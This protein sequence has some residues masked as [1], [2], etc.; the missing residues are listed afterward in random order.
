MMREK[1]KQFLCLT[2][3]ALLVLTMMPSVL[4]ESFAETTASGSEVEKIEKFQ[5]KLVRGTDSDSSTTW[6]PT[7]NAD[8]HRFVYRI[9]Y[10]FSGVGELP[11]E[12]V[13]IRVPKKLIRDRSGKYNDEFDIGVPE[14][15]D[16]DEND[17]FA[18][19]EGTGDD[20]DCY[21]IYNNREISA[22]QAGSIEVSYS[23]KNKVSQYKD[24]QDSDQF[25]ADIQVDNNGTKVTADA[26]ADPVRINTS[27]SITGTSK[28]VPDG[29]FY[30][31]WQDRW[32]EKPSDA[33]DYYYL[34]WEIKSYIKPH[35]TQPYN[36][37]LDDTFDNGDVVAY[38]FGGGNGFQKSNTLKDITPS[39]GNYNERYDYVLTRHK[40]STYS[41]KN[42]YTVY[43]HITATVN[44]VDQVDNDTKAKANASWYYEKPVY[45]HPTGHFYQMKYGLF[46]GPSR[47]LDNNQEYWYAPHID[48]TDFTNE[49]GRDAVTED[50]EDISDY[51]L[52]EFKAGETN[53]ISKLRYFT[54]VR[55]YPYPWTLPEGKTGDDPSDY[56]KEPVTY[57]LIDN[58][59]SIDGT[60]LTKGDYE[61]S[62]LSFNVEQKTAE[63]EE[64][65][66]DF[67]VNG[68]RNFNDSD[69]LDFYVQTGTND[70]HKACSYNLKSEAFTDVNSLYVASTSARRIF[71]TAGVTGYK[72]ETTNAHWFTQVNL[73]PML[74]L[75]NSKTVMNLV[76]DKTKVKLDNASTGYVYNSKGS[77]IFQKDCTGSVYI[78]GV[79]RESQ[80]LK[81]VVGT[82]NNK[83]KKKFTVL[84][85]VMARESYRD[86]EGRHATGQNGGT[87][88]D[89]APKGSSV[90]PDSIE[91]RDGETIL[92]ESDYTTEIKENYK[93]SGRDLLIIKIKKSGT[94]YNFYVNTVHL[95]ENLKELSYN[96]LNSAVYETGNSKIADGLKDTGGSGADKDLLKDIDPDTDAARFLY[97]E[98]WKTADLVTST[99]TGLQKKVKAKEDADY[100]YATTTYPNDDYTYRIRFANDDETKTRNIVFFDSLENY[101]TPEG[102][103]SDWH[104]TLKGVDT[105][106]LVSD[107]IRPVV[108]YSSLENM[109]IYLHHDLDEVVNGQK[110][111]K[112]AS[113][114][115]DISKAK[116]VAIDCRTASDG[117]AFTLAPGKII[118]A[119]LY[120]HSPISVAGKNAIVYNNI[121]IDKD[122]VA[123]NGAVT[124]DLIHQ[125]YTQLKYRVVAD[126]KLCKVQAEDPGKTISGISFRLYG[127]SD[128]EDDIDMTAA[129]GSDGTLTFKRIPAGTYKLQELGGSDD[130]LVDH[131]QKTVRIDENG[132]VTISDITAKEGVWQ[133]PDKPRI[134]GDLKLYKRST[135]RSKEA[136][137]AIKA[138]KEAGENGNVTIDG[139]KFTVISYRA[140]KSAVEVKPEKSV[141]PGDSTPALNSIFLKTMPSGNLLLSL[142]TSASLPIEGT[143]FHL[144]G[145]SD[146][147]NDVSVDGTTDTTGAVVLKNI[148]K[149]TYTLQE[150]KANEDYILNPSQWTVRIDSSGNASIDNGEQYF[151]GWILRNEPRYHDFSLRKVD[152]ENTSQWLSGAEFRLQGVSELG[153]SVDKAVTTDDTGLAE[154]LDIEKGT[155]ILTETKAPEHHQLDAKSYIVTVTA[156]GDVYVDGLSMDEDGHFTFPDKRTL[157]GKITIT[158]KWVDNKSNDNRP[159]PKVHLTTKKPWYEKQAY[160]VY[161]STDQ[162]M[163]FFRDT[164]EKYTD[165]QVSGT[166]TYYTGFEDITGDT[167]PSWYNSS[168][169][170]QKNTIKTALFKDKI[171]P[172]T[173]CCWFNTAGS[174]TSI[175]GLD[176][177]D[178]SKV[179]DMYCMFNGCNS[180][181]SLDVSSFN[182]ANVTDMGYMFGSGLTSLDLSSFNTAK[183]TNM[184]GMFFSCSLLT[185]A[186]PAWI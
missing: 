6:T 146:Y 127:T 43:N 17:D 92:S 133:F 108:Y 85:H 114:F 157:D 138:L 110:V 68:N 14:E 159:V 63:F 116:A 5:A 147:G 64:D 185:T 134:H 176:K 169:Y 179:T 47:Y 91:V 19:R 154:F 100:S 128:Y 174:L 178:T 9:S 33:D 62:S 80:I 173:C 89:L 29:Y 18:Y 8:G 111:W 117:S 10:A 20:K 153:T 83:S 36:F 149:G 170:R 50:S 113:E 103:V 118:S 93:G 98:D 57:K 143:S 183:V 60:Q 44:P 112:T 67:V 55:G 99:T 151:D 39:S 158:K 88:Y 122:S 28:R 105:S 168:K 38:K 139:T 142:K 107:G 56:G 79:K 131:D 4:F 84:W 11:K 70:W 22:A 145:T 109:D 41:S 167:T 156:F 182:T 102:K 27:V 152:A 51:T 1:A 86:N 58:S 35:S 72:M 141:I 21:I 52:T 49:E 24:M 65:K 177:L 69:V 140:D 53:S 119:R 164:A 150:T 75:K 137:S 106:S 129:S 31:T 66:Q 162:S 94:D 165:G 186:S 124:N 132:L 130:W 82:R 135:V 90:D 97:S 37:T 2:I 48:G 163:T 76:K 160:A 101:I 172:K 61:V 180:L 96:L 46:F 161:D 23:L 95:W 77:E 59:V 184:K 126:V 74:T 120:M 181:T 136:A 30:R 42:K 12:S 121:F 73:F 26:E 115:G 3:I 13:K 7:T 40:K 175:T 87:F 104:G 15:R 144:S 155:Y 125:D 45:H 148:E 71:F 32:G 171:K 16:A 25:K 78:M 34:V 54:Y 81:E 166:K 123:N